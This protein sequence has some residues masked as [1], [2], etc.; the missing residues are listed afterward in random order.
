[1][2][3]D[4]CEPMKCKFNHHDLLLNNNNNNKKREQNVKFLGLLSIKPNC[5][6]I[7]VVVGF[8]NKTE[9]KKFF[10]SSGRHKIF[11]FHGMFA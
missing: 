6:L 9:R 5:F 7:L 3:L 8:K 2:C 11:P 10:D 4:E 1:M